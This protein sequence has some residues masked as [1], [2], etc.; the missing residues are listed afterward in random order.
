MSSPRVSIVVVN[1]NNFADTAEC[2]ESLG[3][4]TY[5]NYDVVVVDNASNG[6]DARLLRERF[7]DCIR[8]IENDR[9]CG[10]AEGSNI[11]MRD[12]L[13]RGADYVALLNNDT[14]VAPDFLDDLVAMAQSD[15]RVGIMGGKVYCYET[16]DMIWFAGGVIN[17]WTGSTPIRGSGATDRGQYEEI[18]E[19]DWI[20][21]CFMFITRELLQT[22]G[23]LDKRFFFGWEDAD[24]CVRAA[25]SGFKILF[26]PG[27][28]IWHK[29]FPPEKKERLMG[30]P[31]YYATRGRFIFLEKHFTRLQ[32]ITSALYF[33]VWFPRFSWHYS[34]ILGQRKVPLYIVWGVLGYLRRKYRW[35]VKV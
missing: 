11:G 15:G 25:R 26:V 35:R 32:F 34:R 8:L 24:L 28:R 31:V 20:C 18:A 22:V 27:A 2:L 14:V 12:A 6:D 19:V 5:P 3:K 23:M 10:F 17:Y 9:N 7:A 13:D 16:P 33:L 30:L 1:W 4:T 21:G 29:T